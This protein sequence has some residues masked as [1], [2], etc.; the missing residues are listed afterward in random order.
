MSLVA[1]T[2]TGDIEMYLD[3]IIDN[4]PSSS[5]GN[6]SDPSTSE[7]DTWNTAINFLLANNLASARSNVSGLNYHQTFLI[8]LL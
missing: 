6:Y 1:Q 8:V 5:G 2:A 3:N 7:L 4:V